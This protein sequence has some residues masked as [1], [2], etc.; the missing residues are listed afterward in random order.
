MKFNRE[1]TINAIVLSLDAWLNFIPSIWITFAIILWEG[2]MGGAI[3]VNTFYL[4]SQQFLGEEKEFC[5]GATS[6]SYA[7]SITGA[8]VA[9][10]F[11]TPFLTRARYG[12]HWRTLRPAICT[13]K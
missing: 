10:I 8:A 13:K 11:Y 6:M 9:G 5:L 4:I 2:L 12:P 3:Y 1:Q 7:M